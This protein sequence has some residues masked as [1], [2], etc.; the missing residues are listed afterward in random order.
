[1]PIS[2]GE[3]GAALGM[4]SIAIVLDGGLANQLFQRVAG[5]VLESRF[6][7]RAR[8]STGWLG[9]REEL[10]RHPRSLEIAVDV[11]ERDLRA[12]P[13][14]VVVHAA[15]RLGRSPGSSWLIERNSS[16]DTLTR[17]KA[18]HRFAFGFFQRLDYVEEAWQGLS[19]RLSRS[20]QTD[21]CSTPRTDRELPFTIV[22]VTT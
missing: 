15:R 9:T 7:V 3:S 12:V 17:W 18:S 6:G 2:S 5:L 4:G 22:S 20:P 1:M 14:R 21:N 11:S 19:D 13:S 8:F 16:D 10:G